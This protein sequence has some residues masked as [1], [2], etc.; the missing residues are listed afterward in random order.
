[1]ILTASKNLKQL[2]ISLRVGVFLAIREI[3]RASIWTNG[4]I[5][6][7]MTLTF[8]NLIAVR[9]ILVGLPDGATRA[10][11]QRYTANILISSLR[12]KEYIENSASLL[13]YLKTLPQIDAFSPRYLMQGRL[14]SGYKEQINPTHKLDAAGTTVAG[15]DPTE[16]DKL[17]HLSKYVVEG[18]YLTNDDED[19]IMVG[20]NLLFKYSPIDSPNQPSLKTAGVGSKVRLLL[21]GTSRE[22]TIKGVIKSK[23][24][25]V[26]QRVYMLANQAQ[27]IM[28]RTDLNVGEISIRLEPSVDPNQITNNLK[29][30]GFSEYARIQTATESEPQFLK[31]ISVTFDILGNLIGTIALVVASITIFIVIFVNAITRRKYIGIL[32]G[33]GISSLAIEFSYVLQSAFYAICGVSVGTVLIFQLM[34][35]YFDINPINF[36]FSDGVLIAEPMEVLVRAIILF[37]ATMLAGYLPARLIVKQ[38]TLDAILGR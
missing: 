13:Q 26:D 27:Q 23:V 32:K 19:N 31:D 7:V 12:D 38:N 24:Q 20:A 21:N 1:M 14:E 4:L 10:Q 9:G 11:D 22:V 8:L 36:P 37:G 3:R 35:P 6:F 33:I 29:E 34:K 30:A 15:I 16:E 17:T 25:I 28:G 5:I 2:L 18:N